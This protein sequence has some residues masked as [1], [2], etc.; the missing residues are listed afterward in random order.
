MAG[1]RQS[2]LK[3]YLGWGQNFVD[4]VNL[5][6]FEFRLGHVERVF[7]HPLDKKGYI[8]TLKSQIP[9]NPIGAIL[10]KSV[11]GSLPI[12]GNEKI[13]IPLLRGISDSIAKGDLVL[14]TTIGKQ[15]YY[16]GPI[17]T[18]NQPTETPDIF[19]NILKNPIDDDR[20]NRLDGYS[21]NF[22][23]S[24]PGFKISKL[25]K[26][27]IPSIDFPKDPIGGINGTAY[28]ES[29][30]SDT[31]LDGRHGNS[32][33]V[34]SRHNNPVLNIHNGRSSGVESL[35]EGSLICMTALGSI[36]DNWDQSNV[37]NRNYILSCDTV[38]STN[39]DYKPYNICSGNDE[40]A[41]QH[42]FD[43]NYA[44]IKR[45]LNKENIGNHQM[46][47]FS[48]RITFDA[49]GV[50][51]D[52]NASSRRNIN[53]GAGGNFTLA[54][55]GY[56]VFETKNIYIGK[57]A[58]DRT[59]PMVLGNKL[60]EL[61]VSVME[62]LKNANAL[63]QGIPVPL[64]DSLGTPLLKTEMVTNI[65]TVLDELN[66]PYEGWVESDGDKGFASDRTNSGGPNF[67]SN[68][69]FIEPNREKPESTGVA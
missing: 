65:Q 14:W 47:L 33:R 53:F 38:T 21:I 4:A 57:K 5:P 22:P 55:K 8:G 29:T 3:R 58:K 43:V 50:D 32:I 59:E 56:T 30:F 25:N 23:S 12:F 13:A 19:Y 51:G 28:F 45:A 9:K 6:E 17:N 31:I 41:N 18:T 24:P 37:F 1:T 10:Y 27:P 63:V 15:N 16:L 26:K 40:Q 46:I 61:L 60:R 48:D 35:N 62:L 64:V 11:K 42:F 7:T 52:F 2:P 49:R 69:H 68:H 44:S 20:K 39:S 67:F 54:T 66:E 36:Y 34:G